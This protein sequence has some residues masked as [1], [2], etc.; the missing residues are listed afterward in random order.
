MGGLPSAPI[1]VTAPNDLG[2]KPGQQAELWYYD[3]APF[4]G[5]PGAWRLAGLGTVSQDGTTIVAD[6][7]VGIQRFCGVCGLFCFIARQLEQL[8]RDPDDPTAGDPVD[9]Y[10][11][12]M[13]IEKTDLVL[14][15]RIPAV[16]HRTYNS[17]DPFGAIAGFELGLG[18]A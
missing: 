18:P 15:G 10:L 5:V 2:L 11:G 3:A 8:T 13:I 7:G 17:L 14:P 12:Q 16:I 1:P 9:L 6:A 4:P